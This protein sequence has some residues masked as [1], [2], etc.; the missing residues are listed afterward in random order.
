LNHLVWI[1]GNKSYF[2]PSRSHTY[3]PVLFTERAEFIDFFSLFLQNSTISPPP[4]SIPKLRRRLRLKMANKTFFM[5]K[6]ICDVAYILILFAYTHKKILI[7]KHF[8]SDL[9]LMP[10]NF[11]II[12]PWSRVTFYYL[13]ELNQLFVDTHINWKKNFAWLISF[14]LSFNEH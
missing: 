12:L 4:T 8:S 6:F 1:T 2:F 10:N 14:L 9:L 11:V 13:Q 7:S 3:D 5:G